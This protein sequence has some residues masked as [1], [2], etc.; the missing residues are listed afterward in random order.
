MPKC[1][2]LLGLRL[3]CDEGLERLGL[4][5]VCA[6]PLALLSRLLQLVVRTPAP[7]YACPTRARLVDLMVM[8][9]GLMR[10]YPAKDWALT[11][12]RGKGRG[13][14][15]ECFAFCGRRPLSSVHLLKSRRRCVRAL[16][17]ERRGCAHFTYSPAHDDECR[18]LL[19]GP[20]FCYFL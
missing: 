15:L 1:L 6:G 2:L 10:P 8:G 9:Y 19:G 4:G 16:R 3:V 17:L 11:A 7:A 12:T 18:S 13:Q 14:E 20:L 5:V